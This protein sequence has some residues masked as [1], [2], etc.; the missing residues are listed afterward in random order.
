M[1]GESFNMVEAIIKGKPRNREEVR[2]VVD[3]KCAEMGIS[4]STLAKDHLDTFPHTL[5]C[6][7]HGKASARK[8]PVIA[9]RLVE[10]AGTELKALEN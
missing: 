5:S 7:L 3:I 1:Q 6:L 10:F 9:Q 4:R 2:R 8:H